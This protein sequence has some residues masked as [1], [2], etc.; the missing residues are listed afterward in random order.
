MLYVSVFHFI[1]YKG[2][3]TN[4]KYNVQITIKK[5]KIKNKDKI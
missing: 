2:K 4:Y 1:K 3:S 5:A